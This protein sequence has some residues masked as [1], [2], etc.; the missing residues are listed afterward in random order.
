MNKH[1]LD[2]I[3]PINSIAQSV[4]HWQHESESAGLCIKNAISGLFIVN[5][6]A[7]RYIVKTRMIIPATDR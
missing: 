3:K 5:K 6:N 4:I 2:T 1:L 7:T